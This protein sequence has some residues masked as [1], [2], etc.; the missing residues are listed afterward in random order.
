MKLTFQVTARLRL[1]CA[2]RI[3]DRWSTTEAAWSEGRASLPFW[4][5]A[6]IDA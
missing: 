3:G 2:G 5:L 4:V 6:S 1:R